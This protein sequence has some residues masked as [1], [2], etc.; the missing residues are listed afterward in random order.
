MR[1]AIRL[2]RAR[3]L[4]ACVL[5]ACAPTAAAGKAPTPLARSR[6]LLVVTTRGWDDVPGTLRRFERKGSRGAWAR[7]GREVPVA[8]GRN[9]LAWGLGLVG[10]SGSAGPLK[11]EG[12]GKAP[13]GLFALYSAFG[14]APREEAGWLRL[15]YLP[16]TPAVECVDDPKSNFYNKVMNRDRTVSTVDWNS[17]ERMRSIEG[18]RWGVFVGHNNAP[19]VAGRGS[20]IFLHVWAGPGQGTAGCTAMEEASLTELLRWLD[21]KKRPLLL[22]LP[23][24]EYARRRAAWALPALASDR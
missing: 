13:A 20:C 21:R 15:H 24:S 6:Q 22:Q 8:L 16:L 9:G 11:K 18:Y 19:P 10:M 5:A 23:E 1:K 3:V 17:S 2:L 12:D 7:V 14:F 4:L